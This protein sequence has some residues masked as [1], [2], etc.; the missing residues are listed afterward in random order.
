MYPQ[1]PL[2]DPMKDIYN[3]PSVR[4]S[5]I[6]TVQSQTARGHI[7]V[8]SKAVQAIASKLSYKH[9]IFMGDTKTP[10]LYQENNYKPVKMSIMTLSGKGIAK[11]FN[12]AIRCDQYDLKEIL[13]CIFWINRCNAASPDIYFTDEQQNSLWHIC[14]YGNLHIEILDEGTEK[15][16]QNAIAKTALQP[17][18][19]EHCYSS[20]DKGGSIKGRQT[21]V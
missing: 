2:Y 10:Y 18:D 1:F 8:L 7:S 20:F 11:K 19:E 15:K 5:L 16:I 9:I 21:I 14:K 12:G 3:Y 13:K 17:F 4:R 6:F